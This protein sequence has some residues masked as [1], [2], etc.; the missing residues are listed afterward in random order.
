[1][2]AAHV[3]MIARY[4]ADEP[5]ISRVF[6]RRRTSRVLAARPLALYAARPLASSVCTATTQYFAFR[7]SDWV[8][9]GNLMTI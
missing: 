6:L 7:E 1:V 3:R 9:S 2:R 4:A 5:R 8:L